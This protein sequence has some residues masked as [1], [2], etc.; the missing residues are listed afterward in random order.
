MHGSDTTVNQGST[1]VDRFTISNLAKRWEVRNG[2][3]ICL[4]RIAI[5][6]ISAASRARL[7]QHGTYV[8]PT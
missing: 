3:L 2:S 1:I 6:Y 7:N 5:Y 4:P 8:L